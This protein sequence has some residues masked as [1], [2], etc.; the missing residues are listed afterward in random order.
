[1]SAAEEARIS[2]RV[3][4]GAARSEIVGFTGGV[5]RVKVAAPPVRGKANSELIAL[6]SWA[7]GVDK[8]RIH[9]VLGNTSRS[10]LVAVAGL[11]REEA[12]KRL[13]S[14]QTDEMVI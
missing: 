2:V 8:G 5:L 1:M 3:H 10:K 4:P 7:L 14:D 13:S 6:L 12:V 9:I 11:G